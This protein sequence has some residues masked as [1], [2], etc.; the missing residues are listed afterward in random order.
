METE[1]GPTPFNLVR[2]GQSAEAEI[3]AISAGCSLSS[4]GELWLTFQVTGAVDNIAIP[5][6]RTGVR[7]DGLW[8]TTCFEMFLKRHGEE[9]YAEINVSPS[10]DWAVYAFDAY[11]ANRRHAVGASVIKAVLRRTAETLSL[12]AHVRLRQFTAADCDAYAMGLSTVIEDKHGAKS[13][14]ALAHPSGAPD[15]HHDGSFIGA[16]SKGAH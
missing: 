14:W 13:F 3:E 9:G 16:V 1:H 15:F 12:A 4:G 6:P 5:K 11:R 8:E 2:H 10:T 7:A